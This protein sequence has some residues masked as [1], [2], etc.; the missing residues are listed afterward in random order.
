MYRHRLAASVAAVAL[1]LATVAGPAGAVQP[2]AAPIPPFT[3]V[4][5]YR[6]NSSRTGVYPGPGPVE[7]PVPVWS[8]SISGAINFNPILADGMLLVGGSDHRFYALDAR[9]GAER[10]RF[11]AAD[12]FGRFGSAA[13]GRVVV[14]SADGVLHA[15]DLATGKE[16]WNHPDIGMGT[17]V[18]D[19]VVY[20][21]GTD[22]HAYGID[23]ATGATKWSWAAPG[24]VVY[25]TVADGTAYLSVSDGRLYAIS[26]VDGTELWHVQILAGNPGV[27]EIAGDAVY[28]TGEV[29]DSDLPDGE[30]YA[31]DRNAGTVRWRFRT[32]SGNQITLGATANGALYAGTLDGSGLYALPTIADTSGAAPQPLWHSPTTAE[33]FKNQALTGDILYVPTKDPNEILAVDKSDGAVRWHLPLTGVPNGT[34]AAGGMLFTTDDSGVIAA[35]AEPSLKEAIG[36]TTSGPL[37]AVAAASPEPLANPFTVLRTLDPST[38][39]LHQLQAI[40]I[41]PDG[42]IYAL[43]RKPSVTVIDPA[44]GAVVRTWGRQGTREG[45]FDY[46]NDNKVNIAVGPDGTVFVDDEGNHRVQAFTPDGTFIRQ[47]G[48]FGT[49]EGQFSRPHFVAVDSHSGLYVGDEPSG[50]LTKF[51]PDGAFLWRT[52]GAD[53]SFIAVAE[54]PDGRIEWL[55]DRVPLVTIDPATGQVVDGWGQSGF[56]NGELQ[57]G[58]DLS[59]DSAGNEYI[60]SCDPG[61]TQVFDAGHRLIAGEYQA[62]GDQVLDPVFGSKGEVYATDFTTTDNIYIL[63]DSLLAP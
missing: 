12:E 61:R 14:A 1:Y 17:D 35:H 54:L 57:N 36:S 32:P 25:L 20:A 13:D 15:L 42:L 55:R 2:S 43:D 34:L 18:V 50:S 16:L 63:K 22:Q 38:T 27:A 28:V 33:A 19:G 47:M 60:L 7:Q 41:G 46:P 23:L 26:T 52:P 30:L 10:W 29:G 31:I 8:R 56:G 62:Q 37:D 24:D 44:T 53:P 49:D 6:A 39:K 59:V 40:D 51:G 3:D 58:C 11:E 5:E 48:S 21:P 45:E 9:T 4:P